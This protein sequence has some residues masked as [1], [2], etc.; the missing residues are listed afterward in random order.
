MVTIHS[1]KKRC[2]NSLRNFFAATAFMLCPGH[3]KW[4]PDPEFFYQAGG[5]PVFDMG[6]Y[7]LTALISLMGCVQRVSAVTQTTFSERTIEGERKKLHTLDASQCIKC[8]A[9]FDVCKFDAVIRQ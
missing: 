2:F 9:C 8:G 6:P 3:E 4:H 5:G 7:Y 1:L